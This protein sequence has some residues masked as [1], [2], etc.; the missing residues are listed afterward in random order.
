MSDAH[1]TAARGRLDDVAVV[2]PSVGRASLQALLDSLAASAPGSPRPAE[3]V[4]VDDRRDPRPALTPTPGG[5]LGGA[6]DGV[7]VHVVT[8]GGRG[9]AAARNTGWRATTTAWVS[10]LDD[11]VLVPAGWAAALATDLA[12]CAPGDGATTGRIHVPLPTDRRPTDWERN[13]AGL[14]TAVW[15]TAD[16]AYRRSALIAVGGFDERFPRAY[17]EDADLAVRVTRAGWTVHGGIRSITHPVRPADDRVSIRVQ[18]GNAD[19]ALL[20]ALYGRHWRTVARTGPG[21]GGWHAATVGAAGLAV[22]AGLAQHPRVATA[23][24]LGWAGLTADFARRRIA[25]GP[26]RG[27][28]G[29]TEEVR[30]M[31]LSSAAIPPAAAWHRARGAWRW[32]RGVVP[33]GP[34]DVAGRAGAAGTTGPARTTGTAG[35]AGPTGPGGAVR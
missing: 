31:L 27:E 6:M 7:P 14:A 2:I 1:P 25:P 32:R 20:R 26:A 13:T 4:V 22:A 12:A 21:R 35:A 33:W 3:V 11:D 16:M 18:A 29:R 17:R 23:A 30:R 8:G 9:P 24:A 5:V 10:F 34:A 19:D 28:A 15:A